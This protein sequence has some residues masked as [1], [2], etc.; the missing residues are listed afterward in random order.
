[1][2]KGYLPLVL[3]LGDSLF[4]LLAN[5]DVMH[6]NISKIYPSMYAHHNSLPCPP[7][8]PRTS[9]RAP[10]SHNRHG[11]VGPSFLPIREGDDILLHYYSS[12][13]G[14]APYA[15]GLITTIAKAVFNVD[16]EITH[17]ARREENGHDIFRLSF[18]DLTK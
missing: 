6:T 3:S 9:C 4:Q 15:R 12:R 7:P 8:T 16:A 11:R 18:K 14:I 1:V 5:V 2:D 10:A 17:E 13:E